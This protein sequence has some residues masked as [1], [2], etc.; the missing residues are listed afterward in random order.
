MTPQE[1]KASILQL[2]MQGK[3]TKQMRS[4]GSAQ[5]LVKHLFVDK[6]IILTEPP[7]DIPDNWLWIPVGNLGASLDTDSFSD[8]PFGSNLKTDHQISE[9]EVRIIQLSNIGEDGWKDKNVK[10]LLPEDSSLYLNN[11]FHSE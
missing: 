11:V 3:I 7:F 8:G 1:L 6:K 9:P 5:D 10:Y 2:A 4:D